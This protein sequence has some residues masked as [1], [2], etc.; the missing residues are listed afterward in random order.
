VS[1]IQ[2]LLERKS[3]SFGLKIEIKGVGIRRADH[4]TPLYPQKMA[5]TLPTTGSRSARV[6]SSQTEARELLLLFIYLFQL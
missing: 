4:M 2:E 6:V 3:S 1:T 5:L